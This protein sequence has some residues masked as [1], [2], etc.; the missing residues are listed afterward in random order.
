MSPPCLGSQWG[1]LPWKKPELGVR[2]A[3]TSAKRIFTVFL[4]GKL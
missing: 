2:M 1:P 4:S 3:S